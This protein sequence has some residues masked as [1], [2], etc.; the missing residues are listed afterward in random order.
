MLDLILA[1]DATQ[2][3]SE[4]AETIAEVIERKQRFLDEYIASERASHQDAIG[5]QVLI[6]MLEINIAEL[7]RIRDHLLKP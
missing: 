6:N 2:R 4:V 3:I 1:R 5:R 7:E